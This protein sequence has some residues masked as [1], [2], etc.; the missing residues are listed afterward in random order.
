MRVYELLEKLKKLEE[1]KKRVREKLPT[2]VRSKDT[3][4]TLNYFTDILPLLAD[5]D[6]LK[7]MLER[8][9]VDYAG[10]GI[11]SKNE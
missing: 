1:D 11:G 2:G 3:E 9:Q 7:F 5:A 10:E 6:E 8:L 4:V